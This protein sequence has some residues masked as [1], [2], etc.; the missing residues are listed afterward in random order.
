MPRE[1]VPRQPLCAGL[2]G[3]GLRA[4]VR[5][6]ARDRK[7]LEQP[8]RDIT[9]RALSDKRAQGN[10]AWQAELKLETQWRDSATH[11][12]MPPLEF[13]QRLAAPVPRP[14][15]R[16]AMTASRLAIARVGCPVVADSRH[17]SDPLASRTRR[18]ARGAREDRPE[19]GLT[20]PMG[21]NA[22]APLECRR[23]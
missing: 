7:R 19:Q 12:V 22:N 20:R 21:L 14:R 1:A 17:C 6:E 23:P 9:R 8:C 16:P 13:M 5:R 3:F 2:D 11:V 10:A 15:L 4:A 18:V